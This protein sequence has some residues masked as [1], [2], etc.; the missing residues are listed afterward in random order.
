MQNFGR[1]VSAARQEKGYSQEALATLA[2]VNVRTIQRI[3]ASADKPGGSTYKTIC[4]ILEL[5]FSGKKANEKAQF[6]LATAGKWITEA[7]MLLLI[8]LATV[9]IVGYLTLDSHANTNS[10]VAC[11]IIAVILPLLVI[12]FTSKMNRYSRF[13]YFSSGLLLYAIAASVHP[14]IPEAFVTGLLP[15]ILLFCAVLYFGHS[16]FKLK[17]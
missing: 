1:A 9:S 4:H 6:Y 2:K 17:S 8:N 16:L 7:F 15:A 5:N 13:F 12:S 3:E 14:G 10:K 11:Y